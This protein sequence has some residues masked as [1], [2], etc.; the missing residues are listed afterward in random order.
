MLLLDATFVTCD[1][2]DFR[3]RAIQQLL[4]VDVITP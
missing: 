2:G 1:K 3:N 4:D